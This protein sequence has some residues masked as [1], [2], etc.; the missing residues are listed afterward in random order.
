MAL[1]DAM[2]TATQ[3]RTGSPAGVASGGSPGRITRLQLDA[4]ALVF[5]GGRLRVRVLVAGAPDMALWLR[6]AGQRF[7]VTLED[8]YADAELELPQIQWWWPRGYGAQ[9]RYP[10]VVSLFDS[11]G[12]VLDTAHRQVGFR[13]VQWDGPASGAEPSLL[14]VNGV[15]VRVRGLSWR[16]SGDTDAILGLATTA[17]ANLIHVESGCGSDDLFSRCDELGLLVWQDVATGAAQPAP[18]MLAQI[19]AIAHHPSLVLLRGGQRQLVAGLAPQV[20]FSSADPVFALVEWPATTGRPATAAVAGQALRSELLQLR[21]GPQWW[22][23]VVVA[24]PD[25][26]AG[27]RE[28]VEAV[29]AGYADRAVALQPTDDGVIAT[30]VNDASQG[31]SGLLRLSCR[32]SAG[33]TLAATE[34]LIDVPSRH[35][36]HVPLPAEIVPPAGGAAAIIRAEFDGLH[37]QW[38]RSPVPAGSRQ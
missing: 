8:G 14:V 9:V 34:V 35:N 26:A 15:P 27:E 10:V 17:N 2:T 1:C 11:G 30:V 22:T 19:A 16:A 7:E 36:H 21:C 37:D 20:P 32:V 31:C 13:W 33:A 18:G 12:R 24:V 23:G 29:R 3:P 25:P 38:A 4:E 28:F 5:G 6:V